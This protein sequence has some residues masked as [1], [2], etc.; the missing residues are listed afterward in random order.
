MWDMFGVVDKDT[1][2]MSMTSFWSLCCLLW[3]CFAL[4]SVVSVF[5]LGH[6]GVCGALFVVNTYFYILYSSSGFGKS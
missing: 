4:P 5:D 3:T 2:M 6:V 1:T